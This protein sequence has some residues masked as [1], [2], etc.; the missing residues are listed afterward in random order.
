MVVWLCLL[1]TS[2]PIIIFTPE[3]H[4]TVEFSLLRLVFIGLITLVSFSVARSFHF[5][6]LLFLMVPG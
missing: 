1:D 6:S 3:F 5:A 2:A 4:R